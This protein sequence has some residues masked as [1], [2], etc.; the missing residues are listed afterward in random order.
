[1]E[2][3]KKSLNPLQVIRSLEDGFAAYSEGR[4]TVPPVGLLCFDD[5]PGDCHIK[6][7]YL[8]GSD[9][10]VIKVATG[11]YQNPGIGLP[12]SN[13]L[14]LVFNRRTGNP[15]AILLDHG[16]LTDARTAA[17]GAIAAKYLA[18]RAPQ[19]IGIIGTGTQARMQLEWLSYVTECREVRV[20][21][22]DRRKTELFQRGMAGSPFSI[23]VAPHLDALFA[24]CDL[25]VSTTPSRKPLIHAEQVRPG[26]HITAVGADG[27]GKQELDAAVFEKA[28]ICAVDSVAQCREYGDTSYALRQGLIAEDRL[29]ELGRIVRNP[30]LGRRS[31]DQITI[32]DLTG[33]AVQD[34]QIASLVLAAL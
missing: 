20:W 27:G 5:P 2:Q 4:V 17:A 15:D 14:M 18:R 29:I 23:R 33:V 8:S 3:I 10:F 21:G 13:G 30:D 34:I 7:G 32:A 19:G 12:S 31:E 16:W 25:I 26:T 24:E 9:A 28:D 1:M 11:F 6:Y 22:R